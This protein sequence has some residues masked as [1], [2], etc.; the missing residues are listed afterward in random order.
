MILYNTI[1]H[2]LQMSYYTSF[3]LI[4]EEK[5]NSTTF[6][7]ASQRW[8]RIKWRWEREMWRMFYFFFIDTTLGPVP[9]VAYDEMKSYNNYSKTTHLFQSPFF[10]VLGVRLGELLWLLDAELLRDFT[11]L[12]LE[13]E[14]LRCSA[15][16]KTL[17][18]T[19]W[20]GL[21]EISELELLMSPS[22]C[23]AKLIKTFTKLR[24]ACHF[25]TLVTIH[26]TYLASRQCFICYF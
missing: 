10:D 13:L 17:S 4:W 1:Q 14:L 19:D 18:S 9:W 16:L 7:A 12:S 5:R 6:E 15:L 20:P 3:F 21:S 8:L 11:L 23:I 2:W 22:I 26:I 25:Y 24:H